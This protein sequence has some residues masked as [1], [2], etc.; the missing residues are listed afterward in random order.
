MILADGFM[1]QTCVKDIISLVDNL[2]LML[3]LD[4]SSGCEAG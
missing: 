4:G 3:E 1:R 2:I